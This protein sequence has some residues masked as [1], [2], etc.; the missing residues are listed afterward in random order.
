[1]MTFDYFQ[2]GVGGVGGMVAVWL[3][4]KYAPGVW[5][6]ISSFFGSVEAK[7]Q[8]VTAPIAADVSSVSARLNALE[9]KVT[10]HV[11]TP[12]STAHPAG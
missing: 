12:S 8:S 9:A 3:L 4:M 2:L 10:A 6:W 5:S 1:M 7:V 11:G